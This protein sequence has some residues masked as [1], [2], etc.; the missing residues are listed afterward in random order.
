MN[1]FSRQAT[2]LLV[3]MQMMAST[4]STHAQEAGLLKGRESNTRPSEGLWA[5]AE[6]SFEANGSS[7]DPSGSFNNGV[8]TFGAPV[9][10]LPNMCTVRPVFTAHRYDS[11]IE[12]SMDFGDAGGNCVYFMALQSADPLEPRRGRGDGPNIAASSRAPTTKP[13]HWRRAP[14]WRL[15]PTRSE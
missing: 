8:F 9:R 13:S 14:P 15:R 10:L 6:I 12:R 11:S 3:V 1:A 7:N 5:T 4:L 2:V